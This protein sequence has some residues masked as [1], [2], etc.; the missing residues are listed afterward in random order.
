MSDAIQLTVDLIRRRDNMRR[1]MGDAYQS[2]SEQIQVIISGVH[3]AKGGT[4]ARTV[5]ELT[6]LVASAGHDPSML[7]AAFVDM[8][9]KKGGGK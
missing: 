5:L 9:E 3:A 1:I 8:A 6:N 4:L 7:L 2:E